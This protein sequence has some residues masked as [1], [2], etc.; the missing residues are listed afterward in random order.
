MG[1]GKCGS[2]NWLPKRRNPLSFSVPAELFSP[3]PCLLHSH[4]EIDTKFPLM[5]RLEDSDSTKILTR[6]N[7]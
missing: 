6:E 3:I 4:S 1:L 7:K 5:N 2:I